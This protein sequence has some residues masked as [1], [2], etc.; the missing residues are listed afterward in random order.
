MIRR[1]LAS[2]LVALALVAQIAA[3]AAASGAFARDGGDGAALVL[4]E[5]L[6]GAQSGVTDAGLPQDDSAPAKSVPHD[7][8]HCSMCQLG[9]G[10]ASIATPPVVAVPYN[11]V[12][13]RLELAAYRVRFAQSCL[14]PAAPARAPPV[15]A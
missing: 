9:V 13:I 15:L 12:W 3:A 11:H 10:A 14:N 1:T 7:H 2:L 5:L 6:H 4:C 8:N